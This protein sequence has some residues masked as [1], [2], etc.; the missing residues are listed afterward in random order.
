MRSAE[1]ADDLSVIRRKAIALVL[2]PIKD[3]WARCHEWEGLERSE[4]QASCQPTEHQHQMHLHN[5][6]SMSTS[7]CYAYVCSQE[8]GHCDNHDINVKC[9]IGTHPV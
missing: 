3:G 2:V 6:G 5:Q 9:L 4:I 7:G 8:P 1:K